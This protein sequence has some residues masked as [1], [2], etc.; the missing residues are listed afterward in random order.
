MGDAPKP[1]SFVPIT[2]ALV[3]VTLSGLSAGA[4]VGPSPL[5]VMGTGAS[6]GAAGAVV[7]IAVVES[8]T[9]ENERDTGDCVVSAAGTLVRSIDSTGEG[10]S[11]LLP[12][13]VA[14]A[15][16]RSL[17]GTAGATVATS[18]LKSEEGLNVVPSP[19]AAGLGAM[20]EPFCTTAGAKLVLPL[21]AMT[22]AVVM[23]PGI[24][25]PPAAGA[26]DASSLLTGAN[27]FEPPAPS[28]AGADVAL[29]SCVAG[30]WVGTAL[31]TTGL[32]VSPVPETGEEVA[33]PSASVAL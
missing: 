13:P 29:M 1:P 19:T 2:G 7:G 30:V 33:V 22:G 20:L 25:P 10:G 23:S 27:V 5:C 9:G 17:L 28:F 18:P 6:G 15:S 12:S 26:F 11:V 31:L 21:T 4:I 14:G 8:V 3:V 24:L 16:V 32:G